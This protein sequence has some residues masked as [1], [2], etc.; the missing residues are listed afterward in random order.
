MDADAVRGLST[1]HP[2]A[3]VGLAFGFMAVGSGI[4]YAAL[5]LSRSRLGTIGGNGFYGTIGGNA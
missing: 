2:L 3:L 4:T 1:F 5:A